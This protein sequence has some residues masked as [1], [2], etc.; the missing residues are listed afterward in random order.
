[1]GDVL[2]EFAPAVNV[3]QRR[4][5]ALALTINGAG[6]NTVKTPA[7]GTRL[8]LQYLCLSADGANT[9]DV[10]ATVKWS[11]GATLYKISLKAGAI[12]ARNIGAGRRVLDGAI[13]Q[14]LLVNLS[15][16]QAV[17]VSHESEEF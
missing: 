9:A 4:T 1:M 13:D 16:A 15:A 11:G 8:I 2:E 5:R 12:W 7:T 6:D 3:Y 14:A 10:T 17:H